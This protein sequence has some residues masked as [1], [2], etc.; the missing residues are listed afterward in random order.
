MAKQ[1]CEPS[2]L[3]DPGLEVGEP[4]LRLKCLPRVYSLETRLYD[5]HLRYEGVGGGVQPCALFVR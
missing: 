4:R 3:E 2:R 5:V 1:A